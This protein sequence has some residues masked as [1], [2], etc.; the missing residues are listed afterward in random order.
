MIRWMCNIRVENRISAVELIN[1]LCWNAMK[2]QIRKHYLLVWH[3]GRIKES[4]WPS[5]RLKVVGSLAEE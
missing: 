2:L 1:R 4:L 3:L 5:K